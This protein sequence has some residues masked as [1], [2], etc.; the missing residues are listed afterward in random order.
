MWYKQARALIAHRFPAYTFECLDA[1]PLERIFELV[2]GAEWLGEQE[3]KAAEAS[4]RRG[5][6]GRG[7]R[8]R[9]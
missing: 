2:A 4:S 1:L 8:R 7:S 6:R 9:H 5:G 3:A